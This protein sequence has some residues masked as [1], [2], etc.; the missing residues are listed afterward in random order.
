MKRMRWVSGLLILS[1]ITGS[2]YADI[3]LKSK[4]DV[5]GTWKLQHTKN[6]A[7]AKETIKREDT[8][9]FRDGKITILNIPR[10]GSHYDQ[11]PVNYEIENGKLKIPYV[12]RSGFD[13]F[14]LVEKDDKTMTLKGKFGEIYYFNKK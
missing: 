6:S 3:E 1:L 14:S 2:V 4:N 9:V 13:T 5:E 10:E 11:Q 12:G 7:S 8:W